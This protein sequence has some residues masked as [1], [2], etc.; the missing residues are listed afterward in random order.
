MAPI[1]LPHH[2]WGICRRGR[3]REGASECHQGRH[4]PQIARGTYG[5]RRH[6][7]RTLGLPRPQAGRLAPERIRMDC[8]GAS[9]S[10]GRSSCC[11]SEGCKVMLPA[12]GGRA[13]VCGGTLSAG[14]AK[15]LGARG[16]AT[17]PGASE[18][19]L[20]MCR[21]PCL[22]RER[23]VAVAG[24]QGGEQLAAGGHYV[25]SGS[26]G[27][28]WVP[29]SVADVRLGRSG[30]GRG[31]QQQQAERPK[32]NHAQGILLHRCEAVRR[33]D[34]RLGPQGAIGAR[35]GRPLWVSVPPCQAVQA[36]G[37]RWRALASSGLLAAVRNP[38]C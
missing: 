31:R 16:A 38:G 22:T 35:S 24:L 34:R 19:A 5:R 25:A 18:A 6:G 23:Y 17:S 20:G 3:Q 7:A 33:A 29:P 30:P 37:V 11:Q 12:G 4:Q 1:Q 14:G 10:M 15:H 8:P 9:T 2:P 28:P 21:R 27:S 13:A 26:R 36:C 32:P